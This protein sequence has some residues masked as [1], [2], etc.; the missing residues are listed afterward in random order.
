[1]R[2]RIRP[3]PRRFLNASLAARK[4]SGIQAGKPRAGKSRIFLWIL[5]G[6][7]ACLLIVIAVSSVLRQNQASS[8]QETARTNSDSDTSRGTVPATGSLPAAAPAIGNTPAADSV[9]VQAPPPAPPAPLPPAAPQNPI[10]G[11]WKTTT[12]IG[13][14]IVLR[15]TADGRYTL[16]DVLTSE[17]GV[18]VFSSGDGTLRLQPDSVFSHDIVIWNCQLSGDSLSVVDPQGAGHV[19]SRVR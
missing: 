18:Y 12:F 7:A 14:S 11:E 13:S 2:P 16:K 19:Y 3:Y 8:G 10:I 6:F 17:A 9:P 4:D 5:V 1:M 15:F